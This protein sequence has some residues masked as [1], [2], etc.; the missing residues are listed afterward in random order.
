MF[1][2]LPF[3]ARYKA[4]KDAGFRCVE[5]GFPFGIAVEEVARARRESGIP[6]VLMNIFTGRWSCMR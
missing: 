3:L 6:Q 1:T 2:E 4:A 5:S